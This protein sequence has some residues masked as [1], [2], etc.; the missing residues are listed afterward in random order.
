MEN[1]QSAKD[2]KPLVILKTSKVFHLMV[3]FILIGT[4]CFSIIKILLPVITTGSFAAIDEPRYGIAVKI[5]WFIMA[6]VTVPTFICILSMGLLKRGGACFFYD[7][8]LEVKSLIRG[9]I[10][11]P[12]SQ[13]YVIKKN[14]GRGGLNISTKDRRQD[15]SKKLN[16]WQR[17]KIWYD[18][19]YIGALSNKE[20]GTGLDMSKSVVRVW[21]NYADIP[22]AIQILREKAF[23]FTEE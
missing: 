10:T 5:V 8:R 13:M 1:I 12:Y 15:M 19:I 17:F 4:I 21:K 2:E 14:E 11:I 9:K 7:D 18:D 3:Y 23:S 6:L 22:I 20:I 16:R